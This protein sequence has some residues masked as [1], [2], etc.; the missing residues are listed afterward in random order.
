MRLERVDHVVAAEHRT[1]DPVLGGGVLCY[2]TKHCKGRM[3]NVDILIAMKTAAQNLASMGAEVIRQKVEL[4][5]CATKAM[6]TDNETM[7]RVNADRT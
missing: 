5:V 4:V 7:R 3:H 2:A 1:G 6:N